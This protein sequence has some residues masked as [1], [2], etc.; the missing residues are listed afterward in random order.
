MYTNSERHRALILIFS[1][2]AFAFIILLMILIPA[3][4]L[5]RRLGSPCDLWA[6]TE[7]LSTAL[8]WV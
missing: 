7:A 3:W 4:L 6:M 2:T 1:L 5:V 8:V